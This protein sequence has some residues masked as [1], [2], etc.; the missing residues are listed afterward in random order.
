ME[1]VLPLTTLCHA[2][3]HGPLAWVR[4]CQSSRCSQTSNTVRKQKYPIHCSTCE[5][6]NGAWLWRLVT[7]A[8][9]NLC[10][11]SA[12]LH[13]TPSLTYAAFGAMCTWYDI[14]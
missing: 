5:T 13:G 6:K 14:L 4:L 9:R 12:L 10:C 11:T 2:L 3:L 8:I 1:A 7:F